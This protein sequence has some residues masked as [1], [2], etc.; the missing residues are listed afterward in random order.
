[1]SPQLSSLHTSFRALLITRIRVKKSVIYDGRRQGSVEGKD[2]ILL[3]RQ[4][5]ATQ[6]LFD[7]EFSS[8]LASLL[9]FLPSLDELSRPRQHAGRD[10]H[11]DLLCGIE[12]DDEL[13]LRWL[14]D[15]DVAGL[16]AF[17]DLV[18]VGGGAPP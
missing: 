14:L 12:I 2:P 18:D 5:D 4:L 8:I 9:G 16:G 13:K 3:E 10:R 7:G 15:G 1:M 6:D 17:Q 11:A